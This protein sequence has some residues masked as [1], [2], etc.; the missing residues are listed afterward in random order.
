MTRCYVCGLPT[1]EFTNDIKEC[2]CAEDKHFIHRKCLNQMIVESGAYLCAG[3]REQDIQLEYTKGAKSLFNYLLENNIFWSLLNG[4]LLI[5]NLIWSLRQLYCIQ[6]KEL[7]KSG[8]NRQM[9]QKFITPMIS[10]VSTLYAFHQICM[11]FIG[12]RNTCLVIHFNYNR[13]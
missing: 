2:N 10:L 9:T 11:N 4:V 3:I 13:K 1:E 7:Y 12:W 5:L 6:Y 8:D